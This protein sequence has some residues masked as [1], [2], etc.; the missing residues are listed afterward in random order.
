MSANN[1]CVCPKCKE[2]ED[3]VGSSYGKVSEEEYLAALNQ[4]EQAGEDLTL[5]LRE[6]YEI[7]VD[8][9]GEFFVSYA[10]RCSKCGFNFGYTYS[11][12]LSWR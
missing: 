2:A 6:D 4:R 12:K 3:K 1:W 8:V 11:K 7:G 5:T 9:H 10:C